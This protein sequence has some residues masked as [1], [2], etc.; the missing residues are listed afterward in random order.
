METRKL[1]Y[2]APDSNPEASETALH[3]PRLPLAGV[4]K[5][6]ADQVSKT[7]SE[8]PSVVSV[9]EPDEM[10]SGRQGSELIARLEEVSEALRADLM[11]EGKLGAGV[12]SDVCKAWSRRTGRAFAV[13]LVSLASV[14]SLRFV[15]T[16]WS[17]LTQLPRHPCIIGFHGMEVLQP[18]GANVLPQALILLDFAAGGDVAKLAHLM[19]G[20]SEDLVYHIGHQV[21][22]GLQFCHE[23]GIV[24][25]DIKGAN[26]LLDASGNAQLA[27][28]GSALFLSPSN[29]AEGAKAESSTSTQYG[30]TVAF[31]APELAAAP[32]VGADLFKCDLWSFGCLVV[33][34]LTGSPPWSDKTSAAEI[35]MAVA[36]SPGE[37]LIPSICS[38]PLAAV[39]RRCFV[40][41]PVHRATAVELLHAGFFGDRSEPKAVAQESRMAQIA[42]ALKACVIETLTKTRVRRVMELLAYAPDENLTSRSSGWSARSH[43]QPSALT[44]SM[45]NLTDIRRA[46]L[47]MRSYATNACDVL[48]DVLWGL[49]DLWPYWGDEADLLGEASRLNF[50][51]SVQEDDLECD[52]YGCTFVAVAV[53]TMRASIKALDP[54]C[55]LKAV[56]QSLRSL[57]SAW[58]HP[59]TPIPDALLPIPTL[60]EVFEDAHGYEVVNEEA[61]GVCVESELHS[62]ILLQWLRMARHS[63]N[64]RGEG[65]ICSQLPM[66]RFACVH[67]MWRHCHHMSLALQDAISG[68]QAILLACS[69]ISKHA[70]HSSESQNL[71]SELPSILQATSSAAVA[72]ICRSMLLHNYS[73]M[74][75]QGTWN[76][77]RMKRELQAA[78]TCTSERICTEASSLEGCAE[79]SYGQAWDVVDEDTVDERP[80]EGTK[81][82]EEFEQGADDDVAAPAESDENLVAMALADYDACTESE[83]TFQEGDLLLVFQQHESGWWH[84]ECNGT[85]GWFPSNHVAVQHTLFPIYEGDEAFSPTC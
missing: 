53:D 12:S 47:L 11:L 32:S 6:P 16:E 1:Y 66:N 76:K 78:F 38:P 56:C 30:G 77:G 5:K 17:A 79:S 4:A 39:L 2:E 85:A 23:H 40:K 31:M 68:M 70:E 49:Q 72:V 48:D 65:E 73:C 81:A 84:G 63:L 28:F 20:L 27:D 29:S 64:P 52:L 15:D 80:T 51:A 13:K 44:Y 9:C 26:V 83:L 35:M 19:H 36:S 61:G 54:S 18:D 41:D 46:T 22:E 60:T 14:N 57:S 7:V 37:A 82:A 21:L 25:H 43:Y 24:H 62:G 34:M 74:L 50:S 55:A 58:M 67:S 71:V 69:S 8:T 45:L 3:L 75:H 59:T 10:N 42:H 33:E